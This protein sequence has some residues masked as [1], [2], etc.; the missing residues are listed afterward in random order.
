VDKIQAD[1]LINSYVI[2]N[3]YIPLPCQTEM[4]T[5]FAGEQPVRD[6]FDLHDVVKRIAGFGSPFNT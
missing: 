5:G 6:M 2:L 3:L 1:F 4:E